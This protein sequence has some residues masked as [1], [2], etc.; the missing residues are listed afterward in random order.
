MSF[1]SNG[2]DNGLNKAPNRKE[3]GGVNHGNNRPKEVSGLNH[4]NNAP[5]DVSGLNFDIDAPEEDMADVGFE[6]DVED[7]I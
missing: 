6:D 7:D 3:G 1:K 2:G 5:R 4:G